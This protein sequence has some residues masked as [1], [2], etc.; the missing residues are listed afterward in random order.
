MP[1]KVVFWLKKC[2]KIRI[3]HPF[4]FLKN[5]SSHQCGRKCLCTEKHFFNGKMETALKNNNKKNTSKNSQ[6]SEIWLS[7]FLAQRNRKKS[8]FFSQRLR[9]LGMFG[10]FGDFGALFFLRKMKNSPKKWVCAVSRRSRRAN[11]VPPPRHRNGTGL[12]FSFPT[13]R[14]AES[15]PIL[16]LLV[17]DFCNN[18]SQSS[19][20]TKE[21]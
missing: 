4:F 1:Q 18:Y 5:L 12:N 19:G 10:A 11:Y 2:E 21:D 16:A 17:T 9:R 13:T 14:F 6:I 8:I 20:P 7:Y 3:R 15:R